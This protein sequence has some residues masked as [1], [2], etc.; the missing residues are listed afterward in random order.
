MQIHL[1]TAL[2]MLAVGG[3]LLGLLIHLVKAI[4]PAQDVWMIVVLIASWEV[5]VLYLTAL[6]C[7]W[8][9]AR[10]NPMP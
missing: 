10:R 1:S 2:V 5:Y 9:I 4:Q 8:W 7:E 6:F 3:A